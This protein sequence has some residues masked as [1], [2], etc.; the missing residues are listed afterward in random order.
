MTPGAGRAMTPAAMVRAY[1]S[2]EEPTAIA[3][4]AD[5]TAT[6]VRAVLR[7]QGIRPSEVRRQ[8]IRARLVAQLQQLAR[9]HSR[10]PTQ[11][12]RMAAGIHRQTLVAHFGSV[13]AALLAAGLEPRRTG[14]PRK[15]A[16]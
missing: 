5:V 6:H 14:R 13:E 2:G 1:R 12:E 7:T 4:T 9:R 11:V 10:T 16:E 3:R 8:R 15:E